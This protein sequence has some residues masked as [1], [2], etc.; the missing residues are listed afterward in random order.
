M[1]Q[2]SLSAILFVGTGIVLMAPQVPVIRKVSEYSVHIMLGMLLFSMLSLVFSKTKVMFS[3]L[4]CTAALCI[5]L[6]NASHHNLKLPEENTEQKLNVAHVNLGNITFDFNSILEI[7]NNENIDIVSFQEFNPYWKTILTDQLS[8]QFPYSSLE[9]RIDPYGLA[10]YS[11]EPFIAADTFLCDGI[12]NMSV[13]V[14]KEEKYF[15]V[16]SSYLTPALDRKSLRLAAQQLDVIANKINDSDMPLIALGEYN[17]VY[18]TN[19]IRGFRAKT[20]LQ[21]SRRDLIDG[22]LRV[23]YDHI[24]FSN[25]LECT[26]FKEI[27]DQSQNY[28]GIMGTYQIKKA[29]DEFQTLNSQLSLIE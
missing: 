11:R 26:Q 17:M 2:T 16:I 24:F 29:D 5:F 22:N 15:Q 7:L 10:L 6:K 20:N 23:P 21:N 19:E 4:I 9:V 28:I 14:E 8:D 13:V 12:P 3:G 1:L 25:G 18:W 27:K